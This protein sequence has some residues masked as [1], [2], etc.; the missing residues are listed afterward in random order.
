VVLCFMSFAS[1]CLGTSIAQIAV[2]PQESKIS[3]HD[4]FNISNLG[5]INKTR[6]FD[7]K[8]DYKL[9][10][11]QAILKSTPGDKSWEK[12]KFKPESVSI[13]GMENNVSVKSVGM[14]GK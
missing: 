5:L 14:N 4:C 2:F 10:E 1:V 9:Y 3:Q 6:Q 8:T 13:I 11:N 7:I 12:T